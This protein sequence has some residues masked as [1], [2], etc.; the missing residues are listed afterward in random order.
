MIER[1]CSQLI[2]ASVTPNLLSGRCLFIFLLINS[3]L[4]INSY[5]STLVSNLVQSS[6]KNA[7]KTITD[8]GN[9]QLKIGFDDIPYM[10]SFLNVSELLLD[11]VYDLNQIK[12]SAILSCM[13]LSKQIDY[14]F[15]IQSTQDAELR[16]FITKKVNLNDDSTF[17]KSHDGLQLVRKQRYA[18]HC[19]ANTAF[20]II[21]SMFT[22]SEICK[23]NVLPFRR[24]S[25]QAFVIRRN[26]PFRD[27]FAIKW[28]SA[29]V[30]KIYIKNYSCIHSLVIFIDYFGCVNAV[31][32][33]PPFI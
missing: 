9:S 24:D 7:I 27:I 18:F 8:L 12:K 26:S 33:K 2:G 29:V 14:Y 11:I 25:A 5:T 15:I 13:F 6:S 32:M 20:P 1:L 16:S 17:L 3:L 31:W 19:E 30:A 23:L 22:P 21:R 28:V 10:H 4:L